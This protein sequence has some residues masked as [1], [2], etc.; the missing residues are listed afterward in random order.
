MTRTDLPVTATGKVQKFR[1]QET[2]AEEL[3]A[4]RG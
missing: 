1:L 4:S 2:L 3:R